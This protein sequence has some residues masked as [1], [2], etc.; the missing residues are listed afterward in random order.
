MRITIK[1]ERPNAA[2]FECIH[3]EAGGDLPLTPAQVGEL[4]ERV[5]TKLAKLSGLTGGTEPNEKKK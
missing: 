3:A 5:G 1:I 2:G 4:C